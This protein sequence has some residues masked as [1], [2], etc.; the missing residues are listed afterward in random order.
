VNFFS[1]LTEF[2]TKIE[3]FRALL[4]MS[5][6]GAV[7]AALLFIIKPIIKNRLPKAAQYYL[8]LVVIA[9]FLV[10]F[11][12]FVALPGAAETPTIS[13]AVDWYVVNNAE[14]HDRVKPYEVTSPDGY[15]GV[16]EENW[17]IVEAAVPPSWVPGVVDLVKII[18]AMGALV[19]LSVFVWSYWAFVA[20]LQRRN[21]LTGIDCAVPV[22][23]NA[24][25][26]TPMLVGLFQPV[27]VLPD[28]DYTDT[29]LRAVLL[30]ELTHLRRR[31]LLVKWLSVLACSLHWFN[32]LA[33]LARRELDRACELACDEAVIR[34]LDAE[35][36]QSYGDTLIAVAAESRMPRTVLSTTMCERKKS[37]KE[38]LG[39]IMK[40][41]KTTKLAAAIS[42]ALI[43]FVAAG[44]MLLGA[45]HGNSG[46][47]TR[48]LS[49]FD[50]NGFALG[51]PVG[52]TS[53]LTPT[54]ALDIKDGYV[55]NFEGIRYTLDEELGVVRRMY[56]TIGK[57]GVTTSLSATTARQPWTHIPEITGFFGEGKRGWQDR[58]QKLRYVEYTQK[59]GGLSATVR[60]VYT[61]AEGYLIWVIAESSL[62]YTK[63]AGI[64]PDD[65]GAPQAVIDAAAAT[66]RGDY[67]GTR[68]IGLEG[69]K[70]FGSEFDDW[71]LERV[72]LAYTY[73][74]MDIDVY[75][76]EWRVH[77]TTPEK[78]LLVGGQELDGDGW[79]LDT[80]PN[81]WYILYS[82]GSG[83][84]RGMFNNESEP[85]TDDFTPPLLAALGAMKREQV[86]EYLSALFTDA[87]AP[88]YDGLRYAVSDYAEE[89]LSDGSYT[90]TFLWTMYHLGNGLDV[91]ADLGAEQEAN[92][93]LQVTAGGGTGGR[94]DLGTIVVLADNSAVGPPNYAVP[95]EEYFPTAAN[96]AVPK[97]ASGYEARELTLVGGQDV[98]LAEFPG[99]TF[100]WSDG[101]FRDSG[102]R[103]TFIGGIG[104]YSQSIYLADLTGDGTPEFCSTVQFGSGI[105]DSRIIVYDYAAGRQ[106]QLSDRGLYDYGLSLRDGHLTATQYEYAPPPGD[107]AAIASG[108]LILAEGALTIVGRR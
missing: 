89:L 74:D 103:G 91:A 10:P 100:T 31:D 50:V 36:R 49:R 78:I 18:W 52:D 106:Y 90:A 60:F 57:M 33:W 9:S 105:V 30:H 12:R 21:I 40:H 108:A 35:G 102:T 54:A 53:G 38:R 92:W 97:P 34:K 68:D 70:E 72:E 2:G 64:I 61:D 5:V 84:L 24:K 104:E 56:V 99:V 82:P 95:I 63:P 29:Q 42:A 76:Y 17:A 71:R 73:L 79:Y 23:R 67:D 27:I 69:Q 77:T 58:E 51:S 86:T 107:G 28:R 3:T 7:V 39:A 59:S 25:A 32:P 47:T 88:Y 101:T 55:Y 85:G 4:V 83:L 8:W 26:A 80:Y 13:S 81:A 48:D 43:V 96:G 37:L 41:K 75:C 46:A 66:A 45:G 62:P 65:L 6:T 11:S 22:Y 44:A 87:Y 14:I 15:V 93:S 94:L 19:S 16:P 1:F 20:S 98:T